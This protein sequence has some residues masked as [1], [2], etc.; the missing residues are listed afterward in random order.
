M[1]NTDNTDFLEV[2]KPIPGQNY[3]CLS[4]L[5]P[6]K[7]IKK[8]ELYFMKHFF[9]KM[10]D[11]VHFK[12]LETFLSKY[13]NQSDKPVLGSQLLSEFVEFKKQKLQP[14]VETYNEIFQKYENFRYENDTKINEEFDAENEFQ[15]SVRSIKIR[16]VYDS[17]REAQ[18]RAKVLQRK[19]PSFHVFV[20][21]MGYW[22]PWDPDADKVENQEYQETE[23][24]T[25]M[26]KYKENED[27]RDE[28]YEQDMT[29][30][31]KRIAEENV[32]KRTE[33]KKL[34]EK[35]HADLAS[36]E[37]D[38]GVTES[39]N[40]DIPD[41]DD[42]DLPS[43]DTVPPLDGKS[44]DS[45]DD[46]VAKLKD[47]RG[48]LNEKDADLA[49]QMNKT[50]IEDTNETVMNDTDPWLQ[51]KMASSTV[52]NATTTTTELDNTFE[53]V[54]DSDKNLKTIINDIF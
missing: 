17:I 37:N 15:T 46:T 44:S 52:E 53:E 25:L 50:T 24:N 2:D 38:S 3:T 12:H 6:E 49:A 18:V 51:R 5:S 47:F 8:K 34:L 20:G 42:A 32:R 10:S 33:N 14:S 30:R 35:E 13:F 28:M 39:K 23:L 9:N 31:K 54:K 16:G 48:I 26:Q 27:S 4:F 19:D 29:E 45:T 21:Q 1:E 22:L 7:V 36:K 11:E 41:V 43:L 40:D